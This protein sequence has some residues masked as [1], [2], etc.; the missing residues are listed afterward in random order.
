MDD[1]ANKLGKWAQ[2][3]KVSI[4]NLLFWQFLHQAWQCTNEIHTICTK[5]PCGRES[6]REVCPLLD[7][8]LDAASIQVAGLPVCCT[9]SLRVAM[10]A[11]ATQWKQLFQA[12]WKSNFR[13]VYSITCKCAIILVYVRSDA[14]SDNTDHVGCHL[15]AKTLAEL[16]RSN[17]GNKTIQVNGRFLTITVPSAGCNSEKNKAEVEAHLRYHVAFMYL[18]VVLNMSS[19]EEIKFLTSYLLGGR[20]AKI[21][22]SL[23][24]GLVLFVP[25]EFCFSL[26]YFILNRRETSA[27]WVSVDFVLCYLTF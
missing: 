6:G 11:P 25:A 16:K 27:D 26:M 12:D 4:V 10:S 18:S 13:N 8:C 20:D 15:W 24:A 1:F 19:R 7:T 21:R 23:I 5:Q 9:E 2:T 3:S 14:I 22:V 17:T